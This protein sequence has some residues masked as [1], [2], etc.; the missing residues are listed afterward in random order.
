MDKL[1]RLRAFCDVAEAGGFSRAARETGRSKALLSKYVRELEEELGVRLMNRTTRSLALTDSGQSYLRDV[2]DILGRL[3]AL[4]DEIRDHHCDISGRLRISAP[5]TFGQDFLSRSI[6]EFTAEHPGIELDL[7]LEDRFV[8][9]VQEGYDV[10]IRISILNDSSLVAR[11]LAPARFVTVAHPDVIAEHGVPDHPNVLQALPCI[12]DATLVTPHI[13][14]YSDG[15]SVTNVVVRGRVA[16]NSLSAIEEAAKQKLGFARLPLI[17]V[18]RAIEDGDLQIV[19]A[20]YECNEIG[21]HIV[22]PHRELMSRKVR[23]FID[24]MVKWFRTSPHLHI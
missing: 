21:I 5:A 20:D 14:H 11:K 9:M 8:D 13:W 22:Y 2:R 17:S 6:I 4:E 1:T 16:V 12:L 3:D 10:A 7:R 24:F 19:L 18:H 15:S 23:A